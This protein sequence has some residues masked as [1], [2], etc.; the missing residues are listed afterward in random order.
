MI[1]TEI[2]RVAARFALLLLALPCFAA[3]LEIRYGALERILAEQLFTQEGRHY[4]RGNRTAKCQFA[5][6]ESPHVDSDN[7]LLRV[8][9][10]FS[11]RSAL[12]VM[13]RCIGLGDSFDL[14]VTAAPYSR[15]GAILLKDVKVTAMKDS[16]YIRR[17]RAVMAQSIARDFKIE[18][19]EQARGLLEQTRDQSPYR[20]ELAGFDLGEIRVTPEALVLV[21][22]F[23]LVVK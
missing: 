3:E 15:N 11:G 4:V 16:Y 6:L 23:H 7:G 12:D 14:S 18:V 9:A 21:V 10:R 2:M 5:Y 20:Q 22:E 1:Q 13:N 17:V 8:K 19:R